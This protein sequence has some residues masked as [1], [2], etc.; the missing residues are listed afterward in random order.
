MNRT[1]AKAYA[2]TE[3]GLD[4]ETVRQFGNLS[5]TQTWLDAIAAQ[6]SGGIAAQASGGIAAQ[7]AIALHKTL[8][9]KVSHVQDAINPEATSALAA[10]EAIAPHD[11][12]IVETTSGIAIPEPA[13]QDNSFETFWDSAPELVQPQPLLNVSVLDGD[14][15]APEPPASTVIEVIVY[16][17]VIGLLMLWATI[18]LLLLAS[19]G[20]VM[21]LTALAN[22][23]DAAAS[24]RLSLNTAK[25]S[26]PMDW[27]RI[28]TF[29]VAALRHHRVS[30]LWSAYWPRPGLQS[31]NPSASLSR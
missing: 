17:L 23:L 21:G 27:I 29:S 8:M 19:H 3:L 12:M 14:W 26:E 11:E 16:P 13:A 18:Q 22:A 31:A 24:R 4:R 28:P 15:D 30:R 10:E 5:C 25:S 2:L 1:E 7:D 6:A 9:V 20:I